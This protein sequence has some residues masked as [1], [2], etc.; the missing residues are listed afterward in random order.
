VKVISADCHINEPPHVFERVPEEPLASVQMQVEA[1]A[2]V[3]QEYGLYQIDASQSLDKH[4]IDIGAGERICLPNLARCVSAAGVGYSLVA[5]QQ[6]GAIHQPIDRV[7]RGSVGV[8][9][10]V[11]DV[12]V[13]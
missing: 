2:A 9:P 4:D 5:S 7:E 8:V 1:M 10:A 6:I 13:F 11:V 12:A 3:I